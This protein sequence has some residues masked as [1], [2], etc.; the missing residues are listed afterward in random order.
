[1]AIPNDSIF[2][3]SGPTLVLDLDG[4]LIRNDLTFELFVLCARWS[5]IFFLQ[6][7]FKALFDRSTAKRLLAERYALLIDPSALPYDP[8][9][10]DL[11]EACKRGGQSIELVSGSDEQLVGEIAKHNDIAFFKGS[12][13][14][15][16]LTASRKA[17]FLVDRHGSNFLYIGNSKA[18]ASV[19]QVSQG[20]MASML[21][22]GATG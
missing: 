10:L 9:V 22:A 11:V 12:T 8:D 1:M 21:L 16:D 20:G 7:A 17:E 2:S 15:T 4:T 6:V 14:Q 5:P 13:S 18:D 19:W 3:V